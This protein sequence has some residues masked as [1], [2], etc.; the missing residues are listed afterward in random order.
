MNTFTYR[1][2]DLPSVPPAIQA[3]IVGL[4][5][6]IAD[7]ILM[8]QGNYRALEQLSEIL[9]NALD[10]CKLNLNSIRIIP[11]NSPQPAASFKDLSLDEKRIIYSCSFTNSL[12]LSMLSDVFGIDP[13][14]LAKHIAH[15]VLAH[16]KPVA[17][18]EV[19]NF[20]DDLLSKVQKAKDN[21]FLF[22]RRVGKPSPG[23]SEATEN[24]IQP[25]I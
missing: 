9:D 16:H 7:L 10:S 8:S 5:V 3:K 25:N 13:E 15:E 21:N 20:I 22:E 24:A 14:T 12:L 23:E 4:D 2:S 6:Q 11:D 17:D 1:H 19:E 18:D